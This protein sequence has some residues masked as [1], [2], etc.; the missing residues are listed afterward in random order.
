M[1][2]RLNMATIQTVLTLL[3][4]KWSYRRIARELG[5]HRDTVA[6]LAAESKAATAPPGSDGEPAE[7]KAATAPP[8][9]AAAHP[10]IRSPDSSPGQPSEP[11]PE[12]R[13]SDGSATAV[14][15]RAACREPSPEREG[16]DGSATAVP[17]CPTSR[18]PSPEERGSDG[19]AAAVPVRAACRELPPEGK[20][21]EGSTA[22]AADVRSRS[23][24]QPFTAVIVSKL[25]GGL[26]GQRI[27]QDLVAEHGFAGSYYSVRRFVARLGES[28]D[29]PFRRLECAPGEEL[30]VDFGTGAWIVG[31]DG[32][33]RRSHVL[34]LVLSYS[35]RGYS[36]AVD[37]QTTEN[38][39]RC[40]ENGFWYFGGVPRTVVLDN[41]RAAVQQADW[42]DPELNPKIEAFAAHYGVALLPTKPYTP[43]HKGK[44]ERG[45]D[46][47]QENALKGHTF[48]SLSAANEHLQKWE[49]GIADTRVHGTTRQQVGKLF[50]EVEQAALQ[51]LPRDRFPFFHEGQRT[52]HRD[53]HVEV[54]KAYYS[55]P[56]EYLGRRLWVRWDARVVRI[57]DPRF[58]QLALHVRQEPG[59][60]STQAAHVAATKISGVERGATW[61]LTQVRP[62]G[63]QTTQWAEAMLQARGVAGVRVLQGLLALSRK[64]ASVALEK[65]CATAWSYGAFRLRT[66]RKLL[67]QQ[68]PPQA[69]LP[70][71]DAHPLIRPLSEYAELVHNA[72]T[73]ERMS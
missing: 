4:Q 25:E 35:R 9:S 64:H 5:I 17:V 73:K 31:P 69:M 52:V 11:S 55:V 15:I 20:G 41:L 19:S 47:V 2:N 27:Y 46:Y 14:P 59:R 13:E 22:A 67:Q 26:S 18:E 45:V 30:Q 58:E 34:R 48:P 39:I 7:S 51:A 3:Q 21:A 57:F 28:H 65:A 42:F 63:P 8:S 62:L 40:L 38:F 43:R 32:R 24:C 49:Q 70:F 23:V 29:L 53:G 68:A 56:P 61:L 60:F 1:A 50:R 16:S 72:F 54:A 44:V 10:V 6:R 71:L 12:G 37:R 66:L 33:R 36:E